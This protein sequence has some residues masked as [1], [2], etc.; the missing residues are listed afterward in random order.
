MSSLT[1]KALSLAIMAAAWAAISHLAKVNFELWPAYVGLACFVGAGGGMSGLQ[2]SAASTVSGVVWALIYIA[3]AGALDPGRPG[4]MNALALGVAVF[5][6]VYQARF[7]PLLSYTTGA[8]A[9]A[10]TILGLK[11]GAATVNGGIRAAVP[12][13]IGCV[14][15]IV[16]ERI[17]EMLG[18]MRVVPAMSNR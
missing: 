4:I 9:G 12:L 14:L 16:A 3:L 17:A 5:G 13:L 7:H 6:L 10:A 15:G 18:K 1:T 11:V 2:K 8:I